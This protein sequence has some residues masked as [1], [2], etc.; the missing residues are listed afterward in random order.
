MDNQD[1][2]SVFDQVVNNVYQELKPKEPKVEKKVEI[3]KPKPR[4]YTSNPFSYNFIALKESKLDS[5]P[6]PAS[7]DVMVN[8]LYHAVGRS[9]GIDKPQDWNEYY[10]KVYLISEW[11]KERS[12]LT[13]PAEILK[14][15]GNKSNSIP[16]LGAKKINDLY[17][18]IRLGITKGKKNG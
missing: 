2:Q 1:P 6:T 17:A 10:D 15:I 11:A 12:G 16:S 14:F 5:L 18:H 7:A 4:V 13:D 8:P 9:L 3:K